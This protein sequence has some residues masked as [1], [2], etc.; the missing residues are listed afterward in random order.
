MRI[1][2]TISA[3]QVRDAAR[4]LTEFADDAT[5]LATVR[6]IE[7]AIVDQGARAQAAQG[8]TAVII[9]DLEPGQWQVWKDALM[10]AGAFPRL[11]MTI[12]AALEHD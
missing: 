11:V 2:L 8:G 5:T 10:L 7:Q 1:A 12:G 6:A 3:D 9:I 4:E